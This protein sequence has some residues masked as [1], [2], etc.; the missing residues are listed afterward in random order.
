MNTITTYRKSSETTKRKVDENSEN[1]TEQNPNE[2]KR[3]SLKPWQIFFIVGLVIIIIIIGLVIV[4]TIKKRNQSQCEIKQ[5]SENQDENE[6]S[7]DT[8]DNQ[9]PQDGN[10]IDTGDTG[11]K[12]L[13]KKEALKAFKTNFTIVSKTNKLN[14]VLMKSNLKQTSIS[15]GV[16]STTL[17]VF[18]MAKIDIF[19]LNESYSG[20]DNKEFYSK[21]YFTAITINSICN[22][23]FDNKTDCELQKYLDLNVRNKNLRRNE[24]KNIDLIKDVILP[25]CIVEHTNTNIIISVT[26][27]ETL[28]SNLKE[29]IILSFQSIKPTTA[30]GIVDDDSI[31][32]TNVTQKDNKKYIDSFIKGC[33]DYDGN[34]SIIENCEEIKNIVTDLDGNVISVKKN[35]TK[36]IIKDT[37]HKEN[38]IKTYIKL[39]KF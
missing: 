16:E 18:T 39:R 31:A 35:S 30:Q 1:T 13:T 7:Y 25:I 27:P 34:P 32:G 23:F 29:N 36:E 2:V 19:T 9:N 5:E 24:E 6:P 11:N 28:S 38:I 15:N 26:C 22:V 10:I 12:G 17:S 37:D 20:E 4:I 14:Q 8:K 33:D 21:K 3:K